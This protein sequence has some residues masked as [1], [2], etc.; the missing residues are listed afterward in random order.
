MYQ[1]IVCDDESKILND[2]TEKVQDTFYTHGILAN[3]TSVDDARTLMN[4]LQ[5][6]RIDVLFLDIDMPYYS[7]MEIANYI[8][9]QGLQTL[10]IFVTSHDAL[11]YQTFA[12]RPF[13]FIRKSYIDEEL[14]ALA[15]RVGQELIDRKQELVFSKGQEYIRIRLKEI[16]YIEAEGNYLI[17]YIGNEKIKIRETMMRMESTLCQKGFVRCHKG[18]LVN[19]EYLVKMR[20]MELEL[21]YG[22]EHIVIPIGRSYEKDVRKRILAS[23]D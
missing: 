8:N 4:L 23:L 10:L 14:D 2:I 6:E 3:Y 5:K 11:V 13:G 7:G 15:M 12:Y 21:K 9:T 22:S 1:V 20:T 16:V 18:Y 17:F 19:L